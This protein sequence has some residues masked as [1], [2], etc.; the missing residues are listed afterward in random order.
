MIVLPVRV[1]AWLRLPLRL[2]IRLRP[3]LLLL[4]ILALMIMNACPCVANTEIIN[5]VAGEEREV[6]IPD[7]AYWPK[8]SAIPSTS[9]NT[10]NTLPLS[11]L[12]AHLLPG[13]NMSADEICE[14]EYGYAGY[15][16]VGG[17]VD[18]PARRCPYEGWVV[19]DLDLSLQ[20]QNG[21]GDGDGEVGS[22]A[23]R[24]AWWMVRWRWRFEMF[25]VKVSWPASTPATFDMKVYNPY[26]AF[27]VLYPNSPPPSTNAN[28]NQTHLKY[29][30]ILL[31]SSSPPSASS[32]SA[33]HAHLYTPH[34]FHLHLTP[35]LHPYLPIPLSLLPTVLAI[36][37]VACVAM[38]GVYPFVR[39]WL[40]RVSGDARRELGEGKVKDD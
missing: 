37:L 32:L 40:E 36:V 1:W 23:D 12:P 13:M 24:L 3:P 26:D 20:V 38:G 14:M 7:S 8:I 28:S 16:V 31:S 17:E 15:D 25:S 29:L 27:R 6:Y 39:R 22:W 18:V 2:R 21:D 4:M 35:L 33:T 9:R 34:A 5:F 10:R 30:H 19:L 11:L